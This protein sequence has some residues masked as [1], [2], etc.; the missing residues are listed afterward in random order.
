MN[1]KINIC[2][3]L[4]NVVNDTKLKLLD[5]AST[6]RYVTGP[7]IWRL[8][9]TDIMV[10]GEQTVSNP[11]MLLERNW[12]NPYRRPP[13]GGRQTARD[14]DAYAGRR[15][16]KKR[17]AGCNGQYRDLNLIPPERGADLH[18][19]SHGKIDQGNISQTEGA[20]TGPFRGYPATVSSTSKKR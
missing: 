6:K 2:E 19:V 16:C 13:T 1:G 11:F 15:G 9:G 20:V 5:R 18:L 17:K 7:L 8:G 12:V 4:I 3:L 14:A 10:T